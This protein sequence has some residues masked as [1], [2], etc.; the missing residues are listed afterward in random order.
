MRPSR[1]TA[2][3]D[4]GTPVERGIVALRAHLGDEAASLLQQVMP[5]V[6][7]AAVFLFPLPEDYVGTE[8]WLR[9]AFPAS[10]P[11]STLSLRVEPSP[12]L[13]WPHAMKTG[14]CLHGFKQ[15][16]VTGSPEVVVRDSLSRLSKIISLSLPTADP[17][18]REEEF[19]RET[20][21]YWKQQ[22]PA[23]A[24][25][26]SLLERPSRSCPLVA[27]TIPSMRSRDGIEP[28][29]IANQ[30]SDISAHVRRV[31]GIRVKVRKP[32]HAAFYLKLR[33]YP[34]VEA[35][36]ADA[37]LAWLQPHVAADD[38]AK[39]LFWFGESSTLACRWVALELPGAGNAPIYCL[40]LR[41]PSLQKDRGVRLGVRAG[42]R[43]ERGSHHTKVL[44]ASATL[45][46]LDRTEILSRDMSADALTL[47]NARI[48]VVGQGSLGSPV[49]LHLARAGVGHLTVIDPDE[50][51]SANLGRH[52][53]GTSELGRN[54]AIAMRDR[55]QLDVPIVTV[56]AIP[57]YVEL[58]VLMHPEVFEKADVVISTSADWASEALLWRMKS[59]GASW[60]LI[61]SWSEPHA[62]VGHALVAKD[63]SADARPLFT[64]KGSF[65]HAFTSW[66]DGG[67][68][69]LPACGQSFIPGGGIGMA[70]IAAMVS[71]V[72]ISSLGPPADDRLWVSCLS[73]PQTAEKRGGA[74]VGPDLP[75][76][77]TGMTLTRHWPE[78]TPN[79]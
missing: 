17:A 75:A 64:D 43:Q 44:L 58:S 13:I 67:S 8:R 40:N 25:N 35:P 70:G 68:V 63:G 22:Q 47:S 56:L 30:A 55:L 60:R 34:N 78:A 45:N 51:S 72:A 79:G 49:A 28:V 52:V 26:V 46:V 61:Q 27:I 71:Q 14:L 66:P 11:R 29:W 59:E 37:W 21:S 39:L 31:T 1:L 48:V 33:S 12:W 10:F 41:D 2:L 62:L 36:S 32:A 24:Q 76:G 54:K 65:R 6:G 7:E 74:Y 5:G 4:L 38:F 18:A 69:A 9:I 3:A 57:S 15:K 20:L 77:V 19:Q 23:T 50:L 42:R 73:N 53:L 16:P